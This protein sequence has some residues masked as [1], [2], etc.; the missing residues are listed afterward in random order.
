MQGSAEPGSPLPCGF[1]RTPSSG[2]KL[3]INFVKAIRD[4]LLQVNTWAHTYLAVIDEVHQANGGEVGDARIVFAPTSRAEHGPIVG[5]APSSAVPE[6]AAVIF[7][8]RELLVPKTPNAT[9][10][11]I[12]RAV[13][14]DIRS[15]P[16]KS[17][18]RK[19]VV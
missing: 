8:D 5:D 17:R 18:D 3:D 9:D 10:A 13:L 16:Q 11:L 7:K 4:T 15:T 2:K 14:R 12:A 1:W 6:I 19:S